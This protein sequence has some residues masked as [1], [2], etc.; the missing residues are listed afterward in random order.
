MTAL[1]T[2]RGG[3]VWGV[4]ELDAEDR[5]CSRSLAGLATDRVCEPRVWATG[6]PNVLAHELGHVLGLNHNDDPDNVMHPV[7][8]ELTTETQMTRVHRHAHNLAACVGH[9]PIIDD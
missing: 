2:D 7:P 6:R 8:G 3:F 4:D 9:D 1:L 5:P